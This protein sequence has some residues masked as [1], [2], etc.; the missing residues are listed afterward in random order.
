M[1][2]TKRWFSGAG[3]KRF[4]WTVTGASLAL[5][6]A[7]V[8]AGL[9]SGETTP[10]PPPPPPGFP[11]GVLRLHLGAD[12]Y[13]Q[14]VKSGLPTQT[15]TQAISGKNNCSFTLGNP[16]LVDVT[17]L[18]PPSS[19]VP[20]LVADGFGVKVQGEGNGQPCGRFD[21]PDQTLVL[22]LAGLL[23]DK[24][25]VSAE[26]DL[27]AKFGATID[28]ALWRDGVLKASFVWPRDFIDPGRADDGPDSG[29]LDNFRLQI[30]PTDDA[31]NPI[32]FDEIR[33]T[34]SAGAGSLEGGADGTKACA[35]LLDPPDEDCSEP[36][37]DPSSL[38]GSDTL[39]EL[40]D[41]Y[42][43]EIECL[44]SVTEGDGI[45]SPLATFWRLL[46]E[47]ATSVGECKDLAY[48]FRSNSGDQ[49]VV[50][51][52]REIDPTST[53]KARFSGQMTFLPYLASNPTEARLEYDKDGPGG[54]AGY[55]AMKWCLASSFGELPDGQ[56]VVLNAN[57]P[58]GE[59]YCIASEE[60]VNAAAFAADADP[61]ELPEYWRELRT[62]WW[63]YGIEEDPGFRFG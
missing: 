18:Q 63:V 24:D 39:F 9:A 26:I 11:A 17:A 35:D 30:P 16:T 3:R 45:D 29:D 50:L 33:F 41:V 44:K 4:R 57:L 13:F 56:P 49:T 19:A 7:L 48:I 20:G 54:T 5:L 15:H 27:E 52:P 36:I 28:I 61:D 22:R 51:I 62:T 34:P 8:P 43:G 32:Y 37:I 55:T 46:D 40:V 25:M 21:A 58:S 47:G 31:S 23:A 42:D 6:A 59:T 2:I 14:W 12:D 53:N 38:Y 1:S 10:L 60:T